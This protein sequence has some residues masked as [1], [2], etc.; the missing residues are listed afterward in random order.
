MLGLS[1]VGGLIVGAFTRPDRVGAARDRVPIDAPAQN[2]QF[3]GRWLTRLRDVPR[4]LL[5]R[6]FP[7]LG[8]PWRADRRSHM[9]ARQ[10][11]SGPRDASPVRAAMTAVASGSSEEPT[12]HR[13]EKHS[14]VAPA[15]SAGGCCAVIVN[16]TKVDGDFRRVVGTVLRD[17]G[18]EARWLETRDDD[19]GRA[20]AAEA[21]AGAVD[22]VLTAGGDGTVRVVAHGL[23]RSGIPMGI[24]PAGTGNLLARNLGI[25]L[26]ID[27][28]LDVALTGQTSPIDMVELSVDDRAPERF[29]VMAGTGLDAMIMDEVDPRLKARIGSAAYFVAAGKAFGRVPIPL[30]VTIDGDRTYRRKAML[31][32]IGNV[33]D[34]TGGITLIP[35]A[36]P[37]DGVLHV[38]L[39][40]P[41][42]LGHWVKV[43]ARLAT[44]R[45]R[46]D[47]RVDVWRARRVEIRLQNAD[48]YQIDGDVVGEGRVFR[49]EVLPGALTVR[50]PAND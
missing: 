46:R 16:P 30:E 26:D 1:M 2:G 28:A 41:Q 10:Q 50:V 42:R 47:D 29:V 19:P 24:I 7:D 13:A 11:P 35:Q 4:R 23:A 36:R 37:D 32:V 12:A 33:G 38:Y 17:A 22:L 25:P 8:N 31:C 44:H 3:V 49:A 48:S 45:A 14:Y 40:S 27:A 20:M 21:I 9:D 15:G 6:P 5:E 34:L 43:L 39:A 18:F